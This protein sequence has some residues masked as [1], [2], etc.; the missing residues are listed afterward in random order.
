MNSEKQN[1]M[2]NLDNVTIVCVDCYNYGGAIA[3]L[4]ACNRQVKAARTLFLTDIPP[5]LNYE[6]IEM[7]TIPTIY[8]KNEYSAFI[9]K[10]LHKYIKT[11]YCLIVQHD[12]YILDGSKWSDD[13]LKYDYIGAPWLE[14]DGLNVGNGGFSL[15]SIKLLTAVANDDYIPPIGPEDITICRV[16][17]PY[18]E[19]KYGLKWADSETADRFSY[20]LREPKTGTFGFHG[21]FHKPFKETII[22]KRSGAMGDII[23]MEP[24]M[25]HLVM[26]NNNVVLDIPI[27]YFGL[28]S[29]HL[30]H[31]K[32]I[33]QFDK[34]RIPAKEINLDLAYEVSPRQN[35]LK[36]YFDLCGVTDYR[37]SRPTLYPKITLETRIFP[38]KYAVVHLINRP[39]Q[40]RN[41]HGVKWGEVQKHLDALGYLVVQ[42]GDYQ[43]FNIGTPIHTRTIEFLKWIIAGCDLFIGVDSGPSHIAVAYDKPSVLLFASTNP[44]YV[45]VDHAGIEFVQGNCEKAYC[46][47]SKEG[48]TN[49]IECAFK[50]TPKYLQ[51]GKSSYE[52]IIDA[53]NKLH[54]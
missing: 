24:V 17:R 54:E 38:Q 22:L 37:L 29:Q 1:F 49:G 52:K 33:S 34:D 28:F 18:L 16:Y 42:I 11:D 10:E 40:S 31:V 53:I 7:V 23:L 43:S 45:H 3:A 30:F 21:K 44:D 25:R 9:I 32:H 46:W 36:S 50:D 20:E 39:T 8:S 5:H 48:S 19:E 6:G 13:F 15:R 51:C 2:L 47:H 26:K 14:N 4:Q 12:G 41:I 35:Y 27:Q